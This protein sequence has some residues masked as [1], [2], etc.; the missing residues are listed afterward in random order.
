MRSFRPR[1][2][3][4][5]LVLLAV[6]AIAQAAGAPA[7]TDS[8]RL[9]PAV[10]TGVLPNGLRY[11]LRANA[12]P[13]KRVSLR[14]AVDVGSIAE[15]DAQR[16]L[17]HFTEHMNFNGSRHFKPDELVNYL[18]SI[19][20][21][22]GAD[23]NAYT[24]FD[25]TVYM[26]DVPTD[27][28]SLVVRGLD[29]LADFGGGATLTPAEFEKE[30]GVVLEEW[31]LG[32]GAQ[33]RMRRKH[34]PVI[35]YNSRYAVRLPIG[36][37]EVIQHAPLA[38]LRAFYRDW[39][40]PDHMAVIAVGDMD[41]DRLE[42]LVRV[43]F[44]PAPKP[45]RHLVPP[46]A[47]VPPHDET[48]V[49]IAS[50]KEATSSQVTL[51]YA[52]PL[53]ETRTVADYRAGMVTQLFTMIVNAR[54]RERAHDAPPPF[55]GA[56]CYASRL[57]TTRATMNWT[58]RV[59]DGEI[60]SGLTALLTEIARIQKHGL[61]AGELARAADDLRASAE[62]D[63]AE[64][65]TT[66]SSDLA[67][68]IVAHALGREIML[69]AEDDHRLTLALLPTIT[70]DDLAAEARRV[71]HDDNR[72]LV[73]GVPDKPGAIPAETKLRAILAG[74]AT[75]EVAAYA[76]STAGRTLLAT[77]PQPGAITATR[78][79][80]E[81][82][83]TVWT[84][85]NGAEV[86]L[87]PT[88]FKADE[89]QLTATAPGGTDR[90]PLADLP[91]ARLASAIVGDAGLGGFRATDLD[92]ITA[93]K[94][95]D[96]AAGIGDYDRVGRGSCGVKDLETALQLLYLSFTQPTVDS[97]AF[98]TFLSRMRASL[99]DRANN[100]SAVYLDSLT[101][102]NTGHYARQAPVTA[103]TVDQI[104]L[105]TALDFYR[106]SFA[107]AADFRF[108]FVGAFQPDSIAPLVARYIGG[109]PSTG[110]ATAHGADWPLPRFPARVESLTVA[111]GSAPKSTTTI[112]FFT[113][114][115]TDEM[116]L[117]RA[118][119]AAAILSNRLREKLRED[120][121]GTYG[122]SVRLSTLGP[123]P[124]YGTMTISFGSSP[125]NVARMVAMTLATVDSLRA[126]GP[127]PDE[128]RTEQEIERR[129]LETSEKDNGYWL[130]SLTTVTSYG[131]DPLRILKRRERIETLAPET[132]HTAFTAN[133]P[134]T[135]Y[136]VVTLVPE[137][138][139]E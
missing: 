12:K 74:A 138:R 84:L 51:T 85:S 30:R 4:V 79:L 123:I 131:W 19:G 118:R 72:T 21:R 73:V 16:G 40:T 61:V 69:S 93:G 63:Y 33:E 68:G 18:Q 92:K 47:P 3:L 136:T 94:D 87:K 26:L 27:R 41:L 53:R 45:A 106:A 66:E 70:L 101:A 7:L 122:V 29:A 97:T 127:R 23:A 2:S 5:V 49:S 95:A 44:A 43:H 103:A 77:L 98:A 82:G 24:S 134:R 116:A 50:D 128:V 59:K 105:G 78:R 71:I 83:V 10:R 129:G 132:L 67:G 17:A 20:L 112:T 28:E 121:G 8:L 62:R 99:A 86:W 114:P 1:R 36:L 76:D 31:R 34:L 46:P 64:R 126:F 125:A 119:A 139:H 96:F 124:G 37:P 107:N 117:F 58:A 89:I 88:D 80:P 108:F 130:G 56:F 91:S 60:A 54:L 52:H 111:K 48:L 104:R 42:T 109:L 14:L 39:Y 75:L 100:P 110:H 25:E 13:E 32:Q 65:L 81:L 102:L 120:L 38:Q 57:G 11:Y 15:T 90:V 115:G 6:A 9:D 135:R 133:F 137:A 113:D 35:Y 55:L 22:F